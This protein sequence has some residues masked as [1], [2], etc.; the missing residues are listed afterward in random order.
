MVQGKRCTFGEMALES[1]VVPS[2]VCGSEKVGFQAVD[3]PSEKICGLWILR[4][5][6]FALAICR[7][8][9]GRPP[10]G[11]PLRFYLLDDDSRGTDAWVCNEQ[12]D[13]CFHTTAWSSILPESTR[14]RRAPRSFLPQAKPQE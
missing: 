6:L 7:L 3:V 8:R 13:G 14:S 4:T 11:H 9:G 10:D 2:E 5:R 1:A 12:L